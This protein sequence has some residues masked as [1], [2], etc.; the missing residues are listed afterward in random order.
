[1]DYLFFLNIEHGETIFKIIDAILFL[2][3][4]ITVGY[5][6]IFAFMS[7]GK[8]KNSYPL[9]SKQY[10]FVVLFPAYKEDNVI[11]NSVQ[12]F[13]KQNYPSNKYDIIVISA[14]MQERTNQLLQELNTKVL[15]LKQKHHTKTQALQAAINYIEDE[16][17]NYD[18]V[19]VL[20][21][22]NL[23]DPNF[24]TELNN[25]FYSGCSV[26]QTHRVAKNKNTSIAILD[27]VSEEIN[28]SIFRKGHVRLGFSSGLIGSGMAF[29]YELFRDCIRQAKHIGVDKQLELILL[30]QNIYIEYLSSVYT[31]DEKVKKSSQ[32]Y[33]QRRRWLSTQFHNL[34][35]GI[36][37]I[38]KAI[39]N[40][41]WDYCNKIFQWMLPP[42]IMLLG[43][44]III[45]SLVSIVN[46]Y[47]AIKWW[48]LLVVLFITFAMATPDNLVNKQLIKA[49]FYIPFLF[50]LMFIN[51]FRLPKTNNKFIHTEHNE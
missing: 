1:M 47:I 15:F 5:L 10:K 51:H 13:F 11:I 3:F 18:I 17:I 30:K 34:F 27:A 7:L 23:V 49:F 35:W 8:T 9:A 28:N 37:S 4:A 45:A 41:N 32:F 48:I 46:W 44:L 21:A 42:R 2:V 39:L 24:L 25:A 31:Y 6:F 29:E 12:N 16:K 40:G 20:D 43:L 22:D 33:D 36:T 19:V 26:V 14:E 50:L 38:P